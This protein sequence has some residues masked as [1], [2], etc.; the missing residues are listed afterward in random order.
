MCCRAWTAPSP[1]SCAAMHSSW[2]GRSKK[3]E[4]QHHST[5]AQAP[6]LHCSQ[7]ER[8]ANV[9]T[10]AASMHNRWRCSSSTTT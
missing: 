1:S 7:Q 5:A 8:G 9:G 2:R 3:S 4:Q 10:L 6:A